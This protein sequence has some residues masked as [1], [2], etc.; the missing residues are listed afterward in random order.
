M[1]KLIDRRPRAVAGISE[2][3]I[4]DDTQLL[5]SSGGA[6]SLFL[7]EA[8]QS[9]RPRAQA[10]IHSAYE[11]AFN[12]DLHSFY[13]SI[14]TLNG[15]PGRQQQD[16]LGAVGA[17]SGY[18]QQLFL[19]Q[20]L[21][22]DLDAVLSERIDREVPRAAV[23][24]LGN[25]SVLRPALTYPFMHLIGQWLLGYEVEWLV[26]ALTA[27]LRHLFR[28]AGLDMVELGCAQQHRLLSQETDWGSY[29]EHDPR[30]VALE[31][32]PAIARFGQ[33]HPVRRE[34]APPPAGGSVRQAAWA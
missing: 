2:A 31:L 30:I 6:Y 23:V 22:A 5:E 20:Y 14:I 10:F 34:L 18:G 17:R 27:K 28:R 11:R 12:A 7:V 15:G 25:L 16:I 24:E 4:L 29:Y 26:F 19:E 1:R 8:D 33:F 9:G 13:P 3:A 32:T 21:R